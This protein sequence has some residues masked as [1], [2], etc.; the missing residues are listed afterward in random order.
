MMPLNSQPLTSPSSDSIYLSSSTNTSYGTKSNVATRTNRLIPRSGSTSDLFQIPQSVQNH[1]LRRK[2]N[3]SY[4]MNPNN[5]LNRR[6]IGDHKNNNHSQ[7]NY[8]YM[9][10]HGHSYTSGTPFITPSAVNRPSN[11]STSSLALSSSSRRHSY[12]NHQEPRNNSTPSTTLPISVSSNSLSLKNN[13]TSNLNSSSFASQRRNSIQATARMPVNPRIQQL[14]TKAMKPLPERSSIQIEQEPY[15][16]SPKRHNKSDPRIPL[17]QKHDQRQQVQQKNATPLQ[18]SPLQQQLS[19]NIPLQQANNRSSRTDLPQHYRHHNNHHQTISGNNNNKHNF[20]T[21]KTT[22]RSTKLVTDRNRNGSMRKYSNIYNSSNAYPPS[23]SVTQNVVP[24]TIVNNTPPF[25]TKKKDLTPYQIQRRQM[26]T[27]FQFPNGESFTPRSQFPNSS[28]ILPSS[29]P[30]DSTTSILSSLVPSEEESSTISKNNNNNS[31]KRSKSITTSFLRLKRTDTNDDDKDTDNKTTKSIKRS[32]SQRIGSFFKNFI[33]TKKTVESSDI[34]P[35]NNNYNT[36]DEDLN[37]KF[38]DLGK[39]PEDK[40]TNMPPARSPNRPTLTDTQ[41]A[42][43]FYQKC[44][45]PTTADA[46]N[47]PS[48]ESDTTLDRLKQEWET[49]N[50][51]ENPTSSP[52]PKTVATQALKTKSGTNDSTDSS[53]SSSSLTSSLNTGYSTST[54]VS[55]PTSISLLKA[56]NGKKSLRFATTISLMQTYSPLEYE[57]GG[58]EPTSDKSPYGD[59][60]VFL[61]DYGFINEIKLEINEFKRN[62]MN[63]HHDSSK[64]THYFH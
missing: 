22:H 19:L 30:S 58:L 8:S 33:S 1:P 15:Q 42:K 40:V 6:S 63:V 26:K 49:V 56:N 20:S 54:T 24:T 31:V 57:R 25:L 50:I 3:A 5:Q 2:V 28:Q 18:R 36:S 34:G 45:D 35:L 32:N 16:R 60:V 47:I 41:S 43:R 12:Q 51:I 46:T 48:S 21:L 14:S 13:S 38:A 27:S 9:N 29:F 55:T 37:R 23:K 11:N 53:T 52:N 10:N 61:K 62:E 44:V 4:N 39:H 64:F 59:K 17:Y 7:L